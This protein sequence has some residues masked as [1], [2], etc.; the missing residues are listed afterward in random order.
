M[1][2]L[3]HKVI[4]DKIIRKTW[5]NIRINEKH[6][7]TMSQKCT[8]MSVRTFPPLDWASNSSIGRRLIYPEF[9]IIITDLNINNNV[10]KNYL[11]HVSMILMDEVYCVW[12]APNRIRNKD[13]KTKKTII[14]LHY[15]ILLCLVI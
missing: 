12:K 15:M 13:T 8:P 7:I 3:H 2:T 6:K 10:H 11:V 9:V 5:K 4:F 1:K 14:S